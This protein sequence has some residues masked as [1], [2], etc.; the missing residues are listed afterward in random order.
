MS[1]TYA[2][3]V[4]AYARLREARRIHEVARLM[5]DYARAPRVIIIDMRAERAVRVRRASVMLLLRYVDMSVTRTR[6]YVIRDMRVLRDE[7]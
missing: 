6:V 2:P 1:H 4:R 3:R 5:S 7:R